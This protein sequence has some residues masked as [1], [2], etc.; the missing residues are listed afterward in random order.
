[1]L[2]IRAC[3]SQAGCW[4]GRL[5]LDLSD[6]HATGTFELKARAFSARLPRKSELL[7]LIRRNE[8]E[9]VVQLLLLTSCTRLGDS[10][11]CKRAGQSWFQ[12]LQTCSS[13]YIDVCLRFVSQVPKVE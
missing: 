8:E 9:M 4:A 7:Q 12:R 2:R 10:A 11:G 1:M 3:R 6:A 13:R 5:A